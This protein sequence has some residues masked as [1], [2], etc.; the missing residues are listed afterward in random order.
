MRTLTRVRTLCGR[1]DDRGNA[2][3]EFAIVG[4]TCLLLLLVIFELG[5]MI[6][7]QSV[8]D[9]SARDAARMIRTGQVQASGNAQT[10]FQNQLCA[11]TGWL[12]SCGSMIY[13]A[14]VFSNWSAAQNGLNQPPQRDALGNLVSTGFNAG[15]SKDIVAVQVSYNYKFF[16]LWVSSYLG[17]STQSAF[18]MSTVV[19]QNEPFS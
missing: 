10:S 14:Q 8:L 15:S 1:L 12:I 18:L 3:I 6:L 7:V 13:Q 5:Y 9:S 11:D 16:T 4:P 2:L 19:F 17:G